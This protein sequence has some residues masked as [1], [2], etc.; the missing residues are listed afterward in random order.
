MVK[1]YNPEIKPREHYNKTLRYFY[2]K[3]DGSEI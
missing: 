3:S 2:V 1:E